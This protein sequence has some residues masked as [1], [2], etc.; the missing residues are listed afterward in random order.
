MTKI[1]ELQKNFSSLIKEHKYMLIMLVFFGSIYA[2]ISF[3]NHY[4]FRTYGYD[5][6]IYNNSLFDYSHFR[7][8]DNP[9]MHRMYDNIL[10]DHLSLYHIF[11]APLRFIFG[12]WTLLIIQLIAILFGAIGI[13]RLIDHFS[14]NK[15]YANLA[16][17]HFLSMWGIF[18]AVAYDYHDNVLAAMFV[19]WLLLY[20]FQKNI[21]GIIIWT[22]IIL[23]SK[24]NM[25]FWLAFVFAG[26]FLL[27][28]EDKQMRK[29]SLIGAVVSFIY[30]I[31]ALKVIMPAL[32]NTG[33]S[34]GHIK[35]YSA[36][37]DSM[38]DYLVTMLTKPQ[39]VLSLMF[40][41]TTGDPTYNGIKFEL[42]WVV[43]LSG[44]FVFFKKPQFL[45]MLIPIYMQKMLNSS[46]GK[47]GLN[48]QYSVE[49]APILTFGLFYW[50]IFSNYAQ[51]HK[52]QILIAGTVLCLVTSMAKI[53]SRTSKWYDSHRSRFW[54]GKHYTQSFDVKQVYKWLELIPENAKVSA[55]NLLVP[56]LSFREY[57]YTYPYT[58]DAEYFVVM[59]YEGHHPVDRHVFDSALHVLRTADT[60]EF[61]VNEPHFILAKKK[62]LD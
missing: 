61:L 55:Q 31:L 4:N 59:P 30:F 3:V 47:W 14:S 16:S 9:V 15:Q 33:A 48:S 2:S 50:I 57:I 23:I 42:H 53:D 45:I 8:N 11:F 35:S 52:K 24:E 60:L 43:L 62:P 5:L 51:K 44:G 58:R 10:G 19:P 21:K 13:H 7:I 18:S 56:H 34:Y 25:S 20:F 22:A 6:G 40:E 32:Q 54:Q 26:L 37:G 46:Y 1:V 39:Y 36:L 28:Y 12:T 17:L 29:I 27:K 41:N 49:F 38:G